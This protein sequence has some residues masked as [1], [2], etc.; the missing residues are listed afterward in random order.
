[1]QSY[2]ALIRTQEASGFAIAFPDLPGCSAIAASFQEANLL[3]RTILAR[4]LA[5]LRRRG[6]TCHGPSSMKELQEFGLADGAI[7]LLVPVVREADL[8]ALAG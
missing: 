2:L 5:D 4:H 8:D 6:L 3:A 1:M 7:P